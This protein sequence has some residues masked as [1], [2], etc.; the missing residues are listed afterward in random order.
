MV[1][2]GSPISVAAAFLCLHVLEWCSE[3]AWTAGKASGIETDGSGQP[4]Y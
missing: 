3:C 2:A 1:R 4:I